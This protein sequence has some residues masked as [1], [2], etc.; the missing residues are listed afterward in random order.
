M[1]GVQPEE[2]NPL[3]NPGGQLVQ[4][5]AVVAPTTVAYLPGEQYLH[6][7]DFLMSAYCP[8]RHCSH[9]ERPGADWYFPS[10]QSMQLERATAGPY[11]P[12]RHGVHALAAGPLNDPLPQAAQAEPPAVPM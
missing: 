12:A 9:I 11:R 7:F 10:W 8:A 1:Q 5:A 2:A 6:A 4:T 3:P